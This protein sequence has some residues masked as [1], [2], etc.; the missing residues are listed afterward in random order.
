MRNVKFVICCFVSIFLSFLRN[1]QYFLLFLVFV[2][3]L[4]VLV[5]G[6]APS[7]LIALVVVAVLVVLA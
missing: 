7:R 5:E 3:L 6:L 2:S 1:T 4:V